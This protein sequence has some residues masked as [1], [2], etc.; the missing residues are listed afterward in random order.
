MP[1]LKIYMDWQGAVDGPS[2]YCL[3]TNTIYIN[4][5]YYDHQYPSWM[6]S[7]PLIHEACHWLIYKLPCTV[8]EVVGLSPM[9][10]FHVKLEAFHVW[11]K[12]LIFYKSRNIYK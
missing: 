1:R 11:L 12:D 3:D 6:W 7:I 10:I 5:V 4:P 8:P 2:E 9:W